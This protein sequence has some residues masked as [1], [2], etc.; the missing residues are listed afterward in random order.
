MSSFSWSPLQSAPSGGG[1][2][3]NI[4]LSNLGATAINADLLPGASNSLRLGSP[5]AKW[6]SLNVSAIN[7][8]PATILSISS[9]TAYDGSGVQSIDW[10]SR[11]LS[12]TTT[13]TVLSWANPGEIDVA[14]NVLP[15]TDN[16]YTLGSSVF[17]FKDLYLN[18]AL[19]S[20]STYIQR[21]PF[22]SRTA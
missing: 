12:D 1:S 10:G 5:T 22:C 7:N 20:S 13:A 8:G 2:G 3:A 15:S 4:T 9:Q 16:L 14:A 19:L 21:Q 11:A 18:R 6:L 17:G